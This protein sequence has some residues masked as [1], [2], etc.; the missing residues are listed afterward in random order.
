[1]TLNATYCLSLL[2]SFILILSTLSRSSQPQ[3]DVQLENVSASYRY[4]EQITFSAQLNSATPIG[5]ASIVITDESNGLTQ[6]QPLVIDPAGHAEYRLDTSQN[7]LRPFS[8]VKWIYQFALADGTTFQSQDYSIRYEDN[9]FNWQTLETNAVKVHWYEGEASFGQAAL[10]AAQAG[11]DSSGR[12]IPLNLTQ[13]IDVF[14]YASAEDLRGTLILGGEEWVA[15]HA[16]PALGVVMVLVEP[17]GDQNITLEQRIP[18]ELMHVMT[19]RSVGT[20]YGNLPAWLREGVA[21]LAEIYPNADYD[22]VLKEAGKNNHLISLK[23]LCGSFPSDPGQA[24][25]A[26]TESRSFVNYLHDT[27]G[28]SGLQNLMSTYADGIDCENGTE[29]AFGV[30]L[31]TLEQKWRASILGGNRLLPALQNISPYLVLLCLVLIIPFIGIINTLRKKGS[32][33]GP[34]NSVKK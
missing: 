32:H 3:T 26:Y 7:P 33:H 13:P 16:D 25:L 23:D 24:F 5:Q 17:G 4:G 8:T 9:R 14:I 11:L 18:H 6:V 15:G 20:G 28:S 22:R 30:S 31:S 19:Y 10:N 12:L 27:Y 2:S 34:G 21:S 29:R 1:V